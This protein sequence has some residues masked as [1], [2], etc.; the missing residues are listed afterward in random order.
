MDERLDRRFDSLELRPS[1][2]ASSW[3]RAFDHLQEWIKK[4]EERVTALKG[5]RWKWPT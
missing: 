3:S 4:L 2:Y 5:G 1:S